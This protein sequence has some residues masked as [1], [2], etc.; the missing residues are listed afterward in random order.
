MLEDAAEELVGF[1]VE[2]LAVEPDATEVDLVRADDAE[3]E[4]GDRE[5]PL[6]VVPLA[7]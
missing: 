1:E 5:T 6:L 2:L 4:A 7:A 3:A